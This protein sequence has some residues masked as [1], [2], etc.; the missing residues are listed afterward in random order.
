MNKLLF[1]LVVFLC[2]LASVTFGQQYVPKQTVQSIVH[3]IIIPEEGSLEEAL[4]LT[5]EWTESVLR[6]NEN[7]DEVRLLLSN[8]ES[9]TL[10]LLVLYKFKENVERSTNEINQELI[11]K[12][13]P[14]EN[15]FQQFIAKLHT[16]I[17]PKMNRKSLY[18]ELILE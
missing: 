3:K 5:Q 7:I 16:Y 18:K 4:A 14:G 8:T 2:P 17:D 12:R 1:L 11:K 9:D 15:D 6:K 13:W 10:D